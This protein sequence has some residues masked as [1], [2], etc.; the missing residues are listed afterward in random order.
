MKLSR[1]A[2]IGGVRAVLPH[3]DAVYRVAFR[4]RRNWTIVRLRNYVVEPKVDG[5]RAV[6][7]INGNHGRLIE[8]Q[9]RTPRQDNWANMVE[10]LSRLGAPDLKFGGGPLHLREYLSVLSEIQT[11]E[12]QDLPVSSSLEGRWW[13]LQQQADTFVDRAPYESE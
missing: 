7:L 3:Q 5:Y 10:I 6:H 4:L 11:L 9:L 8:V 13:D 2:D 12:E 1:M